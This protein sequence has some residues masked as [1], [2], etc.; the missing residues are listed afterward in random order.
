MKHLNGLILVTGMAGIL[1]TPAY[2]ADAG[3][4]VFPVDLERKARAEL[5]Y[6]SRERDL[7]AVGSFEADVFMLRIH[8]DVGSFASLDFDLGAI[9]PTGG[10]AEFYGGA[11]LRFLAYD[12]EKF[13]LIP[14]AQ[15]HYSAGVEEDGVK[16]DDLIDFDGGLLLA[17]KL[18]LD[19]SLLLMPYAGPAFSLMRLSGDGGADADAD[20]PVGAVAGLGLVMPGQ[21]TFRFEAQY[22]DNFSFSIAAGIAF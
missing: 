11:G 17:G 1:I 8:S 19:T 9:S 20:T 22:F 10:D 12:S 4:I 2:G 18:E 21:N 7:D 15:G 6:E 16:Y 5:V 13:R 14:F 3:D